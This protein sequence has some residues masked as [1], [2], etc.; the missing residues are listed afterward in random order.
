VDW[1]FLAEDKDKCGAVM[2]TVMNIPVAYLKDVS[3]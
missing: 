3:C 1:I 2:E